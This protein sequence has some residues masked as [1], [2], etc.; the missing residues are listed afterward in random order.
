MPTITITRVEEGNDGTYGAL[1]IDGKAFCV[2]LE[3]P[4]RNNAPNISNIPPGKYHC[5]RIFSEKFGDTFTV[6]NVPGRS[7]IRFHAGNRISDT[8][9]CI[10]LGR[11][12]YALKY[13]RGIANSGATFRLFMAELVDCDEFELTI[14]E[15]T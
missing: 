1:C 3:P 5:R 2:T 4:D 8:E 6:E 7:L 12:Y 13:D 9:G 15:T 10:L 11:S 14:T